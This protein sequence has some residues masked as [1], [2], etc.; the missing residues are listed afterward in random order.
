L[1]ITVR[2]YDVTVGTETIT[3]PLDSVPVPPPSIFPSVFPTAG[4]P[5]IR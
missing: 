2:D 3:V 5:I 1:R 4:L